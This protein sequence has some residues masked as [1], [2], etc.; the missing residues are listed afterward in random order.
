MLM[1]APDRS[2]GYGV[3]GFQPWLRVHQA[4]ETDRVPDA[5]AHAGTHGRRRDLE[6]IA[7]SN[8]KPEPGTYTEAK[9]FP[10]C[11]ADYSSPDSGRN[12]YK[13]IGEA[14][15]PPYD[16]L[17]LHFSISRPGRVHGI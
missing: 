4:H 2:A 7:Q 8:A 15:L 10:D 1:H 6:P 3:H 9:P 13:T 12:I 16:G 17:E 5:R 11:E 14:L